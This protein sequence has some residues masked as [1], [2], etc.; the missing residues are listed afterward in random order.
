MGITLLEKEYAAWKASKSG[1]GGSSGGISG[2]GGSGSGAESENSTSGTRPPSINSTKGGSGSGG[3]N[4]PST[5]GARPPSNSSTKRPS[6]PS[7]PGENHVKQN[8]SDFSDVCKALNGACMDAATFEKYSAFMVNCSS[9]INKD[10]FF[11]AIILFSF[12]ATYKIKIIIAVK[13]LCPFPSNKQLWTMQCTGVYT[14]N[15]KVCRIFN[16]YLHHT[17]PNHGV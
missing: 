4:K 16:N 15:Q 2:A 6:G 11:K 12:K 1:S 17:V 5:S 13:L 10:N 8:C 9:G 14:V 3:E 7:N